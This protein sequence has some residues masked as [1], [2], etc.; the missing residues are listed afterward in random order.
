MEVKPAQGVYRGRLNVG[1]QALFFFGAQRVEEVAEPAPGRG[2]ARH[3]AGVGAG[4]GARRLGG[5][6]KE[7]LLTMKREARHPAYLR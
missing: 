6:E 7:T 4:V 2:P 5:N 3:L 1:R